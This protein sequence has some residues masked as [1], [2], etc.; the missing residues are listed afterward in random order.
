MA[1]TSS[2]IKIIFDGDASGVERAS[3]AAKLAISGFSSSVA[4]MGKAFAILGAANAGVQTIA[5]AAGA[6][7]QLAPAALLLPAAL[8]AGAAAFG[9]FKLATAGFGDALK[10]DADALAKLSPSA[11]ATVGVLNDLKK[12]F[13]EIK[14]LVQESFFK[15]I[16]GDIA[17]LGSTLLPR[18][19]AGLPGIA[20][21]FNNMGRGVLFALK[22]A[23]AQE[24][25][26]KVLTNTTGFLGNMRQ[27]LGHLTSGF[28]SLA[29]VGS[30]FLPRL[31]TAI[32]G[33][34]SKFKVWVDTGIQSGKIESFINNAIAGFVDLGH[35]L[36]NVGSILGSIFSGLSGGAIASP[37]SSIR[38]L[39]DALAA[40]FKSAEAQGPLQALGETLRVVGGVVKDVLL[41][42]LK[43]IGP[44]IEQI[45]P[46][47]QKLA[48]VVGDVLV[49][50]F[51]DLAPPIE[52]FIN[53]LAPI[54]PPLLD[55]IGAVLID[56]VIPALVWAIQ[57][58]SDWVAAT[59]DSAAGT[60]VF[61]TSVGSAMLSFASFVLG[62]VQSVLAALSLLPG[63][64]GETM[65]RAAA[66]VGGAKDRIDAMRASVDLMHDK[67][68]TIQ[69]QTEGQAR[70]NALL[71]TIDSINSKTVTITAVNLGAAAGFAGARA[72][73]GPV[74]PGR[75]YLVGEEGPE[76]LT[77]GGTGGGFVTSSGKTRQALD[78]GPSGDLHADIHIEIGG[79]V[80]RTVNA[81]VDTRNRSDRTR[82]GAG[83]GKGR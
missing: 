83:A 80:V 40:F 36:G 62:A 42:A 46:F 21:E 47:V 4:G 68:V 26:S 15:N 10:G 35:I 30:S 55:A 53:E 11:R 77:M 6:I 61:A 28:V 20:A 73:G 76:L 34:A 23:P 82:A 44:I 5:G 74:D 37:L 50:A 19:K 78:N 12:P 14:S 25:I 72:S 75:S 18:L 48:T 58:L 38:A 3:A 32:D 1:S 67:A 63:S 29:G 65:G 54:I 45:A 49:K 69:A 56:V 31:G 17:Q 33:V 2:K 13:A 51:H 8:L 39:T 24:Q 66:S 16:S 43:F 60:V 41:A 71:S 9:T 81:V 59:K 27:S 70:L 64:F 57:T 52:R 22:Q 79:E 7:Q